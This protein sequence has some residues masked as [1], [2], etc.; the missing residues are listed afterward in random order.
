MKASANSEIFGK[1][2]HNSLLIVDP[3]LYN[4]PLGMRSTSTISPIIKPDPAKNVNVKN[5][6]L[7]SKPAK[8]ISKSANNVVATGMR[9]KLNNNDQV[10]IKAI[11]ALKHKITI[12]V[13]EPKA[14]NRFSQALL[15]LTIAIATV[16]IKAP[17][18]QIM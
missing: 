9:N 12:K 5:E 8:R 13:L 17:T 16:A 3:C 6:S 10:A 11:D 2:E 4:L 14:T 18:N 7:L 1:K 15:L